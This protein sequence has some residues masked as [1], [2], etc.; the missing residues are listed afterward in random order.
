MSSTIAHD[1]A[2]RPLVPLI[3]GLLAVALTGC[4]SADADTET[5]STDP[6]VST[7]T[8]GDGDENADNGDAADADLGTITAGTST[9]TVIDSV[10]CEP[11]QSSDLVTET[12]NAIA[13]GQ[14]SDGDEVLFFAYT[15]EQSGVNANFVDYQGPEGTW[16][17]QGGNA[18]FTVNGGTLSGASLVV[19]EGETESLMLQFTFTIPDELVEC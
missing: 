17:S 11:L 15:Q 1:R 6:E 7:P 5:S 10:N 18:T 19:N 16:S 8:D 9:Y 3:V 4:A 13:I 2:L 12:F 14:S